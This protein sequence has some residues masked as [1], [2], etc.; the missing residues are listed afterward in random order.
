[1]K[2]KPIWKTNYINF[3]ALYEC[4]VCHKNIST[5]HDGMPNFCS[6]CGIAFEWESDEEKRQN[7]AKQILDYW[8]KR[9]TEQTILFLKDIAEIDD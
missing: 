4:P 8:D 7:F 6:D 2:F 3:G 9:G 1:M 5:P